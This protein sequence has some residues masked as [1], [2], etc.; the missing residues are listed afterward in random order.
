MAPGFFLDAAGV[1]HQA[2]LQRHLRYVAMT[3]IDARSQPASIIVG[4]SM[5]V[6]ELGY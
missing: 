6:A 5:A 4:I 1:Q 2:L 3:A